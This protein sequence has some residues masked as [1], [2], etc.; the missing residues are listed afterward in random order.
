MMRWLIGF[1]LALAIGLPAAGWAWKGDIGTPIPIAEV[2][3][4]AE[5]GDYVVVE[6]VVVDVRSGQGS[7]RLATIEDDTGRVIIALPNH[8]LRDVKTTPG[9]TPLYQRVRVAGN[10]DH[11]YM[12]DGTWGIRASAIEQVEDD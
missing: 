9:R 6:G 3:E 2:H 4:K 11:K 8:L 1:V 10:W 5:S 12:D 7:L